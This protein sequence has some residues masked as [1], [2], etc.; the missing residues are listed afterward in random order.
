M[1]KGQRLYNDNCPIYFVPT[2]E[3]IIQVV[4]EV[5]VDITETVVPGILPYYMISNYGRIWHKYKQQFL[6]NNIDSKG[7]LY[8]PLSTIEGSK[9]C[10]IHRLV[11]M[12]FCYFPGCEDRLIN[13][14]S[15]IKT[16]CYIWNL[17]WSTYSENAQH[18]YDNGLNNKERY[19][20]EVIM[21]ICE[22][23]QDPE[24]KMN[25]ISA[26]LDVPYSLIQAIQ[27]KRCHTDISDKYDIK[28]RKINN[29]LSLEQVHLLCQYYQSHPK[30]EI[31]DI[32]CS[33]A[34]RHIG[35]ND[36]N[37]RLVRTAKKIYSKET[38]QYI[39]REYN[40]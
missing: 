35:I 6:T 30:N 40:F 33:K 12:S 24:K 23:L 31:L 8:K 7:Y 4:P 9:N 34:L 14:K 3:N 29:N 16:D 32:Y 1:R 36:V 5:F 2:Q 39:S 17:E 19:P 18:A 21:K 20:D 28:A 38:Y 15:G 26:E 25:D 11:M 10:R 27:N 37:T 13:H 22:L